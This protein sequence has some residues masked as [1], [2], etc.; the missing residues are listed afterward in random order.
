MALAPAPPLPLIRWARRSEVRRVQGPTTNGPQGPMPGTDESAGERI[1]R[2]RQ[3]SRAKAAGGCA[4][5]SLVRIS[6]SV[7]FYQNFR[8]FSNFGR[9]QND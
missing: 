5:R 1:G 3:G 6:F 8:N 9:D 7:K 4:A 2:R